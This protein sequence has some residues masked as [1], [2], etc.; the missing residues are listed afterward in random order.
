MTAVTPADHDCNILYH[1]LFFFIKKAS[2][3][4]IT[5]YFHSLGKVENVFPSIWTLI[6]GPFGNG[7]PRGT[8]AQGQTEKLG[9]FRVASSVC[10][11]A[12]S[13]NTRPAMSK[14]LWILGFSVTSVKIWR[15]G[16]FMYVFWLCALIVSRE[17]L[18]FD[19]L[20]C[21]VNFS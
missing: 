14:R 4:S 15:L 5:Q 19:V 20:L 13:D 6:D 8:K 16:A 2:I 9:H 18:F 11:T 17:E 7:Q 10:F 3:S 12:V 21:D 1:I